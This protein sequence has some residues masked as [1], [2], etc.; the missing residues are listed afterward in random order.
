MSMEQVENPRLSRRNFIKR[1]LQVALGAAVVITPVLTSAESHLRRSLSLYHTHTRQHLDIVYAYGQAY[2]DVALE[3][4]N[5]FLRDFRT[6]ET[7]P[8][9]TYLLDIL[10]RL[11]QDVGGR[12][13]Y[14]VI[15]GYRSP[16]TNQ[17][18]R[19]NS[20]GV[21]QKSLHMEGRAIDIRFTQVP[22]KHLRQCAMA[23]QCGGVGYYPESD[24]VHID[25]GK[26][27]FW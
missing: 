12:G 25:T 13:G 21:A 10:W 6:G 9:D 19:Q 15:S 22:T 24:F 1:S 16:V 11:Q 20:N 8:I 7:H 27:R 23:L 26:V 4:I 18:L 17:N 5:Y 14:E 3:K 2:D